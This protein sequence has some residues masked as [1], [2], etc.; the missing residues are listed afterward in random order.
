[1]VA[2]RST[3]GTG[4]SLSF[5]RLHV[6]L[7]NDHR[8]MA[9][10]ALKRLLANGRLTAVPKRPADQE[11]FVVLAASQI[12]AHRGCLER[13]VNERLRI[14]L[15]A[16]SEPYGIDHVTLRRMLVDS[17]LLTRTSSGSMYQINLAMLGEIEAVRG[18]EPAAVLAQ[19]QSERDLRKRQRAT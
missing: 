3:R 11:L 4:K 10:R 13:E 12:D 8:E 6:E 16:I 9:Y 15:E 1:M 18:I 19:V 7:M 5:I 17:G 14:W 2:G